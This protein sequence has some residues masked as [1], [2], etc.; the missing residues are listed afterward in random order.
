[1]LWLH[2]WVV[3]GG[4]NKNHRYGR[5][6]YLYETALTLWCRK[7]GQLWWQ[8]LAHILPAK[9]KEQVDDMEQKTRVFLPEVASMTVETPRRSAAGRGDPGMLT[10]SE[11]TGWILRLLRSRSSVSKSRR[12]WGVSLG[13]WDCSTEELE[14]MTVVWPEGWMVLNW[15]WGPIHRRRWGPVWVTIST[16]DSHSSSSCPLWSEAR[17]S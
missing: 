3:R 2:I 15:N 7:S 16:W 10:G 17:L 6:E 12:G 9:T 5:I 14:E 4:G 13:P 11:R 8:Q 1:M